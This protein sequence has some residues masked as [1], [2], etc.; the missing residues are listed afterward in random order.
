M[1]R[2]VCTLIPDI[3]L[4]VV[5]YIII[6]LCTIRITTAVLDRHT[7]CDSARSRYKVKV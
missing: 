4:F 7:Y 1:R 6:M 5:Y 3:V 2:Y